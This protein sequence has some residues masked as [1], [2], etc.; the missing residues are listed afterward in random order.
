MGKSKKSGG[1]STTSIAG[2]NLGLAEELLRGLLLIEG[3]SK[4]ESI[5]F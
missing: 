3:S 1:D 4:Q 5:T 2:W